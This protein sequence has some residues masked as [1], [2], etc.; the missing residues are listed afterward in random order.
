[1]NQRPPKSDLRCQPALGASAPG[2]FVC[3][4]SSS[5]AGFM[6]LLSPC[7][8]PLFTSPQGWCSAT[9]C[10]CSRLPI[11]RASHVH[12]MHNLHN[13]NSSQLTTR[14]RFKSKNDLS[15]KLAAHA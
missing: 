4:S 6:H 10:R 9:F 7:L 15:E 11:H 1:M 8:I 3:T 5:D 2:T 12:N 14:P 13:A